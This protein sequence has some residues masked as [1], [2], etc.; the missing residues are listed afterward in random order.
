MTAFWRNPEP[1]NVDAKVKTIYIN[2]FNSYM[3]YL[4]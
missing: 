2:I 3:F 4:R 1:F